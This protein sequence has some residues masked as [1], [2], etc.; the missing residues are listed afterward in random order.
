MLKV[1]NTFESL[2]KKEL[3]SILKEE[4]SKISVVDI[5]QACKNSFLL[6]Q[7]LRF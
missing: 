1:I 3:L 5:M 7:N 4:A 2:R 6:H